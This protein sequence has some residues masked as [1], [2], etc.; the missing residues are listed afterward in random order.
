MQS[1]TLLYHNLEQRN[2]SDRTIK[3]FFV[4][5]YCIS[6][7]EHKLSILEHKLSILEHKRG[8]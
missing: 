4:W 2:V 8:A 3:V 5:F 6:I 7:L 1:Y